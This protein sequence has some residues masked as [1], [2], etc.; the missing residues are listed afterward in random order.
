MKDL[1]GIIERLK[2]VI[3]AIGLAELDT[4]VHDVIEELKGRAPYG[5]FEST[6]A[7]HLWDEYSWGCIEGRPNLYS[8]LRFVVGAC[9][10]SELDKRDDYTLT[11]LTEYSRELLGIPCDDEEVGQSDIDRAAI[12]NACLDKISEEVS[13]RN[14]GVLGPDRCYVISSY[15]TADGPVF[16]TYN[17]D[18]LAPHIDVLIDP[19]GDLSPVADEVIESFISTLCEESCNPDLEDFLD[20][21]NDEVYAML[22]TKEVIPALEDVRSEL[23]AELDG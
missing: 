16:S 2:G 1:P 12:I 8:N 21:Y 7:R 20:R 17:T 15:V 6:L 11:C 13:S 10:D 5:M 19:S 23:L 22:K 4:L 3:A 14:L 18:N 9:I